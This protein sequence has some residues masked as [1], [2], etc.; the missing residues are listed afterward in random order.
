MTEP[1]LS[2][3]GISRRYSDGGSGN[4]I[5]VLDGVD[6]DVFSG[7]MVAVQGPSGCGK[8]TLLKIA[9]GLL[10]PNAGSVTLAG[11]PIAYATPRDVAALRRRHLGYISQEFDLIESE[12]VLSNVSLPLMYERPRA[13]RRTRRE[14]V[15][16]ALELSAFP[17]VPRG[18][19]VRLLSRGEK[20]RV[21]IARAILRNP[22]LLV[23]DE[24]TAALDTGTAQRIIETLRRIADIGVAVLIAT[25]DEAIVQHCHR[26]LRFEGPRLVV[27]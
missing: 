7:E 24:P 11:T 13:P 20:Q 23:A 25:H 17:D 4:L 14:L 26:T 19:K 10:P 15:D 21:A 1:A 16:H 3:R 22:T 9:G 2:V 12:S 6:L 5:T 18:K 27:P 8:S